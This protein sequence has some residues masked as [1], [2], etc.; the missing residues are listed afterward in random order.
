MY[1]NPRTKSVP[2]YGFSAEPE[3]PKLKIAAKSPEVTTTVEAVPLPFP[4]DVAVIPPTTEA[5]QAGFVYGLQTVQPWSKFFHFPKGTN[6]NVDGPGPYNGD[7]TVMEN[8]A[9]VLKFDMH[10]PAISI[11]GYQLPKADLIFE[12]TYT[13]DG[14]GNHGK[15]TVNGNQLTDKN[16][17]INT[18]GNTRTIIPSITIPGH[19]LKYMTL[20]P[21][22][23]REIDL[24]IKIDGTEYDFDLEI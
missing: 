20:K 13:K 16:L 4:E 21:D 2:I 11:F 19:T 6:F 22:G 3:D 18:S 1:T 7:G 17:T 12:L 15:I 9:N 24:D 5:V 8:T 10:M 14:P 23:T